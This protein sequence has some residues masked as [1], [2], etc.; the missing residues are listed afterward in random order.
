MGSRAPTDEI[1]EKSSLKLLQSIV[2]VGLHPEN[3]SDVC[4]AWVEHSEDK[5]TLQHFESLLNT[6]YIQNSKYFENSTL[7]PAGMPK[8]SHTIIEDN[9]FVLDSHLDVVFLGKKA[10]DLL[11]LSLNHKAEHIFETDPQNIFETTLESDGKVSFG[12]VMGPE[13]KRHLASVA[14]V[15]TKNKTKTLFKFTLWKIDLSKQAEKYIR[16]NLHLT[17]TEIEILKLCLQRQSIHEISETRGSSL[18]TIRTHIKNIKNKYRSHSL[19]DVI[20]ST[21]EIIAIHHT[22]RAGSTNFKNK[23]VPQQRNVTLAHLPSTPSS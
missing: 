12:D 10:A 11:G 16:D 17:H 18:N 23:Y 15:S 3:F 13:G 1:Q 21:H 4:K 20:S 5:E 9:S 14:R 6:V 22:E 2:D 8:E 7:T 19:T